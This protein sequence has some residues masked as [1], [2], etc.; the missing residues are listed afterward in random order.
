MPL[1]TKIIYLGLVNYFVTKSTNRCTTQA[2]LTCYVMW[3]YKCRNVFHFQGDAKRNRTL[4]KKKRWKVAYPLLYLPMHVI[5]STGDI[6]VLSLAG[7][8]RI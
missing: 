4:K 2:F 3:L 8:S 5:G 6:A 7:R 1:S